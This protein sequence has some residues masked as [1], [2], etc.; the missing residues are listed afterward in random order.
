MSGKFSKG[1][2]HETLGVVTGWFY[3]G[4]M[5][6]WVTKPRYGGKQNPFLSVTTLVV[7]TPQLMTRG[8]AK[9]NC[10]L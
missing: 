9:M 3:F 2:L 4:K 7:T 5:N 6:P 8:N 10:V 1:I